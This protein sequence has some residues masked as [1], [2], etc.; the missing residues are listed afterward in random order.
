MRTLKKIG[1]LAL[2]FVAGCA[3]QLAGQLVVPA[4]RAGTNPTRW[5]YMCI[6]GPGSTGNPLTT[7][8]DKLGA[9]GWE[10]AAGVGRGAE[11]AVPAWCF[12][13]ALP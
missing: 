10:L 2:A 9:Q 5:E 11:G 1:V 8:M 3:A 12:K 13:R 6:D 4:A 7:D